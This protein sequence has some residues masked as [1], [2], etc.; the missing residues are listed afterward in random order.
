MHAERNTNVLIEMI[1]IKRDRTVFI[2]TIAQDFK[3]RLYLHEGVGLLHAPL[4]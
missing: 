4:D 2:A 1:I 3:Y